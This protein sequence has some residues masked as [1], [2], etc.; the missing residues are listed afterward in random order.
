[1]LIDHEK[2]I[3]RIIDLLKADKNIYDPTNPSGK[4]R[5]IFFAETDYD[6]Q[7]DTTPYCYVQI[8]DQYQKTKSIIGTE[9]TD[10][11]QSFATYNIVTVVQKQNTAS[12]QKQMHA[13]TSGVM[14]VLKANPKLKKTDGTD[15]LA[16]RM[17]LS[18][19][20]LLFPRGREKQA[21]ILTI[22]IQIGSGWQLVL[23]NASTLELISVPNDITN[24]DS[25]VNLLDDG[26]ETYTRKAIHGSLA[27]EYESDFS[28]DSVIDSLIDGNEKT[29]TL[30][31]G[32]F[33][34]NLTVV[35]SERRKTVSFDTIDRTVLTMFVL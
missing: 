28:T 11:F 4:F 1:M 2:I 27:V 25:D 29:V 34:K 7:D 26:S 23:P 5:K 30:K 16:V 33:T 21:S 19:I 32:T 31:K 13:L 12:A 10:F 6:L 18:D 20:R 24:L 15:P 9:K 3:N 22:E 14:D 35:F 17:L 8:A